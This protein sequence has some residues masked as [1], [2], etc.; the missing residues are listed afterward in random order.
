MAKKIFADI[1]GKKELYNVIHYSCESFVDKEDGRSPRVTS[2]AIH[3]LS[4]GQTE[5]FSIYQEAERKGV[6][7]SDILRNYD[8]LEAAMLTSYFAFM[9]LNSARVFLH[10]NMRD[11]N[12][13]FK[14]L[15]HRAEILGVKSIFVLPDSQKIDI[16]RLLKQ[17]YGPYY[18]SNPK[19]VNILEKNKMTPRGLLP[20]PDEA[21]AFERREYVKL[22]Q[23][24]LA[25]VGAI[26]RLI[27]AAANEELKTDSRFWEIYGL[28]VGGIWQALTSHWLGALLLSILSALL[29]AALGEW[30]EGL[31]PK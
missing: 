1:D 5:S 23:S 25:K 10:W 11:I 4:S 22:R 28:S 12:Y 7:L 6:S 24:T 16:A 17:K 18:I 15:E 2:I 21:E 27:D 29:G 30:V 19:L 31:F 20:G 3:N 26:A 9:R 14:A 8:K 13:G